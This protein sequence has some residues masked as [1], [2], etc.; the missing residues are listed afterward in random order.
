VPVFRGV[1]RRYRTQRSIPSIDARIEF[2][3]RTA[4]SS[5]GGPKFQPHWLAAA[6][7][8]FVNKNSNY[9]MQFGV[10]FPYEKSVEIKTSRAI[11]L[12]AE[13]WIGCKPVIDLA[14]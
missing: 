10:V 13:A 1:Q 9:Q 2:D 7:G 4:F 6:Y 11:D 3:L 14:K 12:I 5:S 8:A